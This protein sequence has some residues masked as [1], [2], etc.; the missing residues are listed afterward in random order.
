MWRQ[1][2]QVSLQHQK[3]NA[4]FCISENCMWLSNGHSV[5][6]SQGLGLT[7]GVNHKTVKLVEQNVYSRRIPLER[8]DFIFQQCW[9]EERWP[10][11]IRII[12]ILFQIHVHVWVCSVEEHSVYETTGFTGTKW[13][14]LTVLW[15]NGFPE[16]LSLLHKP[17]PAFKIELLNF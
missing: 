8:W 17:Y 16:W 9:S 13:E 6:V 5:G 4:V 2:S 7:L 10:T 14:N 12:K 11:K 3:T 1:D 15:R